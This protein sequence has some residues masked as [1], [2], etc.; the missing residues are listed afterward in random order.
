M[1][2]GL[3]FVSVIAFLIAFGPVTHSFA[4]DTD[5]GKEMFLKYC[6]SCHGTRGKGDGPVSRDLKVKVTDL[7]LLRRNNKGTYPLDKV[8][9]SIDGSR[10][11][12]AHGS[13]SMPVWGEVFRQ[14][15]EK[16]K[17]TE[18]TSLLKAK[19][20]AEYVGTLQK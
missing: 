1:N 12:R 19:L 14:E 2:I 20:I 5:G 7:T 17:Y 11:V 9:A 18:L 16:E 13:R 15:H 3:L 4:A 10:S 8:M 6:S